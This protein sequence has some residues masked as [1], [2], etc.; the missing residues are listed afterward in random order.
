MMVSG[1]I[2]NIMEKVALLGMMVKFM[3]GI[4]CRIKDTERAY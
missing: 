4:M 2:I 3:K 1:K